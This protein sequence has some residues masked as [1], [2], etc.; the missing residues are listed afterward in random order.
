MRIDRAAGSGGRY[1]SPPRVTRSPIPRGGAALGDQI[2]A[3]VAAGFAGSFLGDVPEHELPALLDGASLLELDPGDAIF[4]EGTRHPRVGVLLEG[5]ART[6]L[7]SSDGRCLTVRYVRLG[8]LISNAYGLLGDRARLD[9][10]AL[11]SC[12]ILE[13]DADR[14]LERSRSESRVAVAMTSEILRR[15]EDVY[16]CL[17]ATAFATSRERVAAHLLELA[18][19]PPGGG[20]VVR[21]TQQRLADSLGTVR[22]VVAR[23]LQGLREEGVVRTGNGGIAITDPVRLVTIAGRWRPRPGLYQVAS[24]S[25]PERVLETLPEAVVAIDARGD[26]VFANARAEAVFRWDRNDLVGMPLE[27]LLPDEAAEPFR[28]AIGA[29]MA[30]PRPGP[31]GLGRAL[32]GRRRDGTEFPAEISLTPVETGAGRLVFATVIDL[33]FRERVQRLVRDYVAASASRPS[34]GP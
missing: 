18:E 11:S 4:P 28:A 19:T 1:C 10:E 3:F 20:F 29:F 21:V 30:Q 32:H 7:R 12:V 2:R 14:L 16:H 34:P 15:L 27:R 13:L 33:G 26:I 31:I 25:G 24:A 23:A 5:R 17:A 6:F 22:E 8:S 9:V